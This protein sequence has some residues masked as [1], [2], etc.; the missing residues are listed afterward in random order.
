MIEASVVYFILKAFG[1]SL[2]I[3]TTQFIYVISSLIGSISFLPGG[4]GTTEGGLL[5]LLFLQEISYDDALGPVLVIRLIALW[6]TIL[7]GIIM[8]RIIEITILKGK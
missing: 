8:C 7:F 3:I 1:I 2:S 6:M 5:G 4:I